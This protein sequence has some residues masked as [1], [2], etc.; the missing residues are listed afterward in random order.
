MF[1]RE[2][3]SSVQMRLYTL[4]K[5]SFVLVFLVFFACFGLAVF[6]GLLGPPIIQ[7]S[8]QNASSLKPAP[9]PSVMRRG[10]FNLLSPPLN[11]LHQ[12]LWLVAKFFVDESQYDRKLEYGLT[13]S[14]NLTRG[15]GARCGSFFSGPHSRM[16]R[17]RCD[18]RACSQMT[19]FHLSY[20]NCSRYSVQVGFSGLE[21]VSGEMLSVR[22]VQFGF[23]TYSPAFTQAEIWLRFLLLLASFV[24]VCLFMHSLRRFLLRDWSIEQRWMALLL[25]L[26]LLYNDPLLPLTFLV[27]HWLPS[28][29]DTVFQATFLCT[30]LMFWL[31]IYH[32]VRENERHFCRFYLPKLVIVAAMWLFALVISGW[33]TAHELRDPTYFYRLDTGNFM[34]LKVTFL[35]ICGLYV[36]Y[37]VYLVVRAFAELRSMPYFDLRLK[38]S[39]FLMLIVIGVT[40]AIAAMRWGS[41]VLDDSFVAEVSARYD[42][43]A[44][45]VSFY[46]LLNFYLFAMAFVY[47]PSRN[48]AHET[49]FKDD[50]GV[51]MV[52]DSDEDAVYESDVTENSFMLKP[53]GRAAGLG[54]R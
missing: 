54:A 2:I 18:R 15:R 41:G 20:I 40:I 1:A 29:L 21:N 49:Q 26:L 8:V 52:T 22:D 4:S 5:R 46:C 28:M 34:A 37:L 47:S 38:F 14:V 24:A 25:P 10:P 30:L 48:A 11:L 17:L 42:N 23:V 6:V 19:L 51:S 9:T 32:S 27:N 33:Q 12:Q 36:L 44:E 53:G 35:T 45:F 16:R 7:Q 39:T 3:E 31:C 13:V 50:P 43:S